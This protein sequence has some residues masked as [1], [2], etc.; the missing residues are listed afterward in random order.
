MYTYTHPR[1]A[2][3]VD[4]VVLRQSDSGPEILLIQRADDP[5]KGRWAFPGGF[6]DEDEDLEVAAR[7]E[8]QEETGLT[9]LVLSQLCAVGTPGRDPRGHTVS[10]IYVAACPAPDSSVVAG[11]DAATAQWFSL[12]SLPELAFDHEDILRHVRVR[13]EENVYDES[14]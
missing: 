12:D 1:P 10:V 14:E 5:F 3:T 2:V 9:S 7:R 13:T 11:D 4:I 6:V 8:L